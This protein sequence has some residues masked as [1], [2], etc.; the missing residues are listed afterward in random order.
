EWDPLADVADDVAAMLEHV[1]ADVDIPQHSQGW[2][3]NQGPHGVEGLI[4]TPLC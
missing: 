4:E 2:D 3:L 1:A